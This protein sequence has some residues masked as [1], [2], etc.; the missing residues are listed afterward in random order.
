MPAYDSDSLKGQIQR[1]E[2]G[3]RCAWL[4]AAVLSGMLIF[5]VLG[6]LL[7][8]DMSLTFYLTLSLTGFLFAQPAAGDARL[9]TASRRWML[10]V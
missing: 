7:T 3:E 9:S 6:Q 5:A 2:G 1:R 8:L 10:V 4:A